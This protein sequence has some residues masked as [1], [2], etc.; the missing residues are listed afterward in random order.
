MGVLDSQLSQLS[1]SYLNYFWRIFSYQV[2]FY[3]FVSCKFILLASVLS[4]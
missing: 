4:H 1:Q 3:P 2:K